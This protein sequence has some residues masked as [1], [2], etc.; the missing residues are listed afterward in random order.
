MEII[1]LEKVNKLGDIGQTV[2]VKPGYARNFLFPNKIAIRATEENKQVFE[3]KKDQ[4]QKIN[5]EKKK[6]AEELIAKVPNSVV[7]YREA[8]EQGALFGSVTSRDVVNEINNNSELSLKAKDFTIKQ[9]I[10][11]IGEYSGILS[12][13]PEVS[14]DIIIN[15]KTIE[16]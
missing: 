15:V 3:K 13:H 14:K 12:L 5:L 7:I 8:S 4:L 6:M 16:K 10:K 2:K 9:I 11:N 1:L